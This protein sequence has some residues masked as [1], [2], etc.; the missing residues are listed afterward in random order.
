MRSLTVT[1]CAAQSCG[2][3]FDDSVRLRRSAEKKAPLLPPLLLLPLLP[4]LPLLLP[5]AMLLP[6]EEKY[7][8]VLRGD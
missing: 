5:R 6:R 8:R 3:V 4:L 2:A 1:G 7:F